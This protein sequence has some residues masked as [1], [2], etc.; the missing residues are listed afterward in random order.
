MIE[1]KA[2]PG[3]N[4]GRLEEG[5]THGSKQCGNRPPGEGRGSHTIEPAIELTRSYSARTVLLDYG[6]R[7]FT[8]SASLSPQ[9]KVSRTVIGILGA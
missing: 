7:T 9:N 5:E 6:S 8:L 4:S 2:R 1:V 3:L